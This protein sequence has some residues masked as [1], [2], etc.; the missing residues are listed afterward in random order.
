MPQESLS[1]TSPL[2]APGYPGFAEISR[3]FAPGWFAAVMGSGALALVTHSLSARWPWLAP[4]AVALH[5]FNLVL[6][7]LLAVPWLN[8]WLRFPDAALA[9][10]R[11]P[12][13]ASFY[14]TFAIAMLILAAQWLAICGRAGPALVFW[15]GGVALVFLFSFA[16]LFQMFRGTHVGLEHVT[17]AKFIPAVGLVVVPLA[18]GPLLDH[19]SG[20]ARDLALLLN[21]LG[22]GAGV[23]MYLGLLGLTLHRKLLATPAAG[24]LTPTAWIHLAPLGVIPA[25]LLNLL[26]RLPFAVPQAPFLFLSL[27]LWGFG[28]WWLLMASLLTLSARRAGQLPFALS[29]WGF[30][31]PLGAFAATS[32]RL[33]S[34]SGIVGIDA[35]GVACWLLL[36][37]LWSL[38]LWHT[39]R[40]VASG[41]VFRPHP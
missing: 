39:V 32:L 27:L 37:G 18:G 14:P 25:S 2:P 1:P 23:M 20:A 16:V 38:T 29:W 12:V 5:W 36:L 24:V 30:T 7:G 28:V 35:V 6:F 40:G 4:L 31:F 9:T 34:A 21:V 13:Q 8:R 22:L 41:A 26:D 33:G 10:L 11:H 17:P 15:W 3:G 19:Q